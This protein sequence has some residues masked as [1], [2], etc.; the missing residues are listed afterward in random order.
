MIWT[1]YLIFLP[2]VF[3]AVIKLN[4]SPKRNQIERIIES[5][6]IQ[7]DLI[8]FLRF[9]EFIRFIY[10]CSEYSKILDREY[11]KVLTE[12]PVTKESYK[13]CD[14]KLRAEIRRLYRYYMIEIPRLDC[15]EKFL[16]SSFPFNH[17]W[18]LFQL[19]KFS[20]ND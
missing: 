3:S 4:N 20:P 15:K 1:L 9:P 10:T 5:G 12:I 13:E 11:E 7:V 14:E 16:F 18:M 6:I 19:G 8:C 2:L 17:Q